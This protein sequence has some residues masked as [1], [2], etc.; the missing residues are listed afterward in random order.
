MIYKA[1][2]ILDKEQDN[3][4]IFDGEFKQ[5]LIFSRLKNARDYLK[6]NKVEGE[7]ISEVIITTNL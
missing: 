7:F 5:V 1:Y 2:A 6:Q 4:P 3:N